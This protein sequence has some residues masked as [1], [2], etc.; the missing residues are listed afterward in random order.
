[1][2]TEED[3]ETT[4][5]EFEEEPGDELPADPID[6]PSGP[7]KERTE[8]SDVLPSAENEPETAP[9]PKPSPEEGAGEPRA[10]DHTQPPAEP[11][12]TEPLT[13]LNSAEQP[14]QEP[15]PAPTSDEL[16]EDPADS[17]APKRPSPASEEPT[18][19]DRPSPS[20]EPAALDRPSP[21]EEPA[22]Q[23]Q[24]SPSGKLTEP[25]DR[26]SPSSEELTAPDRPSPSGEFT[27]PSD[28]LSPSSDELAEPED[29]PSLPSE[30]S[31]EAAAS[32]RTSPSEDSGES[33]A[34]ERPSLPGEVPGESAASDWAASSFEEPA[35]ESGQ[36]ARVGWPLRPGA[37]PREGWQEEPWTGPSDDLPEEFGAVPGYEAPPETGGRHKSPVGPSSKPSTGWTDRPKDQATPGTDDEA[38]PATDYAS[39]SES[40]YTSPSG[41]DYTSASGTDYASPSDYTSRA[42]YAST[43]GSDYTSPFGTDYMSGTD[44]AS[45]SGTG[46]ESDSGTDSESVFWTDRESGSGTDSESAFW[47]DRETGSG[48]GR[49]SAFGTGRESG[50]GTGRAYGSGAR[51]VRTGP[52][53]GRRGSARGRTDGEDTGALPVGGRSA[54]SRRA[55]K[56]PSAAATFFGVLAAVLGGLWK[57]F[58][59]V[60]WPAGRFLRRLSSPETRPRWM[61]RLPGNRFALAALIALAVAALYGVASFARPAA[62]EPPGPRRVVPPAATAVCPAPSDTRV[63]AVTSPQSH[64]LGRVQVAGGPPSLTKPGTAWSAKAKKGSGTW[65]FDASG[66]LAPG[67]TVEQTS[68]HGALEGVRCAE[69]AADQ[70][71]MGPGPAEAKYVD[72]SLSNADDRNVSVSVEG[73]SEDG[74][75]ESVGGHDIPVGGH[76]TRVIHVGKEPDGLG[77]VASGVKIIALRVHAANGRIAAAVRVQRKKGADWLPA[78]RPGSNLVVPGVAPGTGARRLLVAV[79]GRD[80]ATVEVEIMSPDGTFVPAGQR[81]LQAAA[82]AVTPLDLGLGGKPAG[83][84]LVS[85]HPIVASL[86]AEQDDDFAVSAAVPALGEGG[87]VAGDQDRSSLLLT[88]PETAAVVRV[89]QIMAQG[90]AATG[91]DVRVPAG[92]TIEV[93]MPSPASAGGYALSVVPRPGSGRVYAARFLKVKH[94]GITLLPIGPARTSILLPFVKLVPLP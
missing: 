43:S 2:S 63:S 81:I 46:R 16:H 73:L 14:D 23:D 74:S 25:A 34:P 27:D 51:E 84:R 20:E 94:Q 38:A 30:P 33:A 80:E 60:A 76:T 13:T 90:S 56:P 85:D 49:E 79:P 7:D 21:S 11:A 55:K 9:I 87:L 86:V 58:A 77:D 37:R 61:T 24:P 54:G 65:T 44:D 57:V 83:I 5:D 35:E 91:K 18:T 19:S 78:T 31:P 50:S 32:D 28:R 3:P 48:T 72:L 88:A 66:A 42:D 59:W 82:L 69:P 89:T 17:A 6:E 70:W 92:R 29:R 64:G 71:F 10:S 22:A 53:H 67:L 52:R 45:G 36:A 75:L 68:T 12:E 1:M 4:S 62:S 26:P 40:D 15:P 39:A 41:T 93:T 8:H 47:T